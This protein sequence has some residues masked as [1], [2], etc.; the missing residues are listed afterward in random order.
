MTY[1]KMVTALS[2]TIALSGVST[3][4]MA[5]DGSLRLRTMLADRHGFGV[6]ADESTTNNEAGERKKLIMNNDELFLDTIERNEK[7]DPEN[8]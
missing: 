2:M 7:K 5:E 3:A 8:S 6:N 1:H 4:I